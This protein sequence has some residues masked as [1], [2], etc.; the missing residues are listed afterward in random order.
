M[1]RAIHELSGRKGGFVAVNV[2]GLDDNVFSD[3]LFGHVRGAFTGA[4]KSRG[5]LIEQAFDGTLFLDEIGDLTPPSQA[6]MLRLLQ[7]GDYFPL[8][9]DVPKHSN[10]RVL[11]AT[12]RDLWSMANRGVFRRDLNYRLRTHH[13]NIPPLRERID[14]LPLLMDRFVEDAATELNK[15]KPLVTE[16]LLRALETYSFPGNVREL[17]A[18]VF[19]AMSLNNSRTLSSELFEQHMSEVQ[20]GPSIDAPAQTPGSATAIVFPSTLPTLKQANEL[21]MREALRRA[22]GNQSLAGRMLG[23]SQQAVSKRLRTAGAKKS[24]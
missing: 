5:G 16:K 13:I 8:G 10:A 24:C 2:A 7:E 14:D 15:Q 6:K 9:Q 1:A 18:M 22:K 11:S 19:N 4:D 12:N 20:G 21:L 3:T 23:I 17:R